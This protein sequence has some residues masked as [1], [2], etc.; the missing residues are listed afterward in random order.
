MT[1]DRSKLERELIALLS[2]TA[3]ID[4]STVTPESDLAKLGVDSLK[5]V[6]LIFEIEDRYQITI[7]YNANDGTLESFGALVDMVAVLI[8]DK[9][10]TGAS[11]LLSSV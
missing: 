9:A 3:K 5:V 4:A 6:E 2:E 11:A 8:E 10:S 7:D 1:T